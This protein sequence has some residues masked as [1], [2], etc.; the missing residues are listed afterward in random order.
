MCDRH[1]SR[2]IPV[3]DQEKDAPNAPVGTL[4]L[5]NEELRLKYDLI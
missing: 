4:H 3:R 5:P 1:R 2:L